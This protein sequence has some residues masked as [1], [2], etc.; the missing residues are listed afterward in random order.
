MYATVGVQYQVVV[1]TPVYGTVRDSLE[2]CMRVHSLR[3]STTF[4]GRET[5]REMTIESAEWP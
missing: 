1:A 4:V 3:T 2:T 5:E